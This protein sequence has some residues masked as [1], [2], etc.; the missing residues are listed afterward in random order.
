MVKNKI[1]HTSFIQRHQFSHYPVLFGI[2]DIFSSTQESNKPMSSTLQ[3]SDVFLPDA[4]H[5]TD[6][7]ITDLLVFDVIFS[8]IGLAHSR[9]SSVCSPRTFWRFSV[10][11]WPIR[12]VLHTRPGI[13][14]CLEASGIFPAI[15]FIVRIEFFNIWV[16]I[17][18]IFH[19]FIFLS[20]KLL[21]SFDRH[22]LW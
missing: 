19:S 1:S 18:L 11:T 9:G 14:H 4:H 10:A 6:V 22:W 8:C 5:I 13:L 16:K 7:H 21:N 12:T 20:S 15:S 3:A 2:S 17:K